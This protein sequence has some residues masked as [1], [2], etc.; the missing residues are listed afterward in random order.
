MKKLSIIL[1]LG[2]ILSLNL[3]SRDDG[4]QDIKARQSFKRLILSAHPLPESVKTI[5]SPIPLA[6]K[7]PL[8]FFLN[9]SMTVD[10]L[11]TYKMQNESSIAVNP[12][13]PNMLIGSAVDYRDES[14]TWVYFS[15]DAGKSWVNY[16]LGKAIPNW[17]S[18]ND[19]SVAYDGDGYAYLV[20]GGFGDINSKDWGVNFGENGVFISIS[21]DGGKTWDSSNTHI[22][23]ILHKGPQTID[24]TF[25]D[26]Y[27]IS[28]DNSVSSPYHNNLYIPWKRVTPKDSA[29]QIVFSKSTDKGKTWSTPLAVSPRKSGSSE[30]TTYGQSFPLV[31]TGPLG[32]IYLVWNDGIVH[33]VGFAKSTDGGDSFSEPSI[34]QHY[35]I[36]GITNDI[37]TNSQTGPVWRHTLKKVVRSEA[38]PVIVCDTTNSQF[39]G[40][41]YLTWAA[42]RIPNIYFSK[43]TDGGESW[44][45]P[46]IVHSDT[47]NDQF[48][49]WMAVDPKTGDIAVMYL[50]SR[51]DPDNIMVECYVSYSSDGGDTWTDRKVSD[52]NSDLRKNPFGSHFA[53]DYS[54]M[55]FYDGMIYPS[56]VD[57]RNAEKNIYDSDVYT[58]LIDVNS[59]MPVNNFKANTIAEYPDKIQLIWQAP[60]ERSFGQALNLNDYH[61]LLVRENNYFDIASYKT[62]F[63]DSNLNSYEKYHYKIYVVAGNDTSYFREDSAYAGGSKLPA[64]AG[65]I[66]AKGN[67]SNQ[68]ILYVK[69]P[70]KRADGITPLINLDNLALYDKDDNLLDTFHLSV[71]DTNKIISMEYNAD[72]SGYYQV[73]VKVRDSNFPANESDK[74]NSI[75]VFTGHISNGFFDNFD[76]GLMRYNVEGSWNLTNS[77]YYSADYSLTD[78][79]DGN[80]KK[81][82]ENYVYLYPVIFTKDYISLYFMHAAIVQKRDTAKVE[83]STN[84]GKTWLKLAGFNKTDYSYWN[85][86]V[87]NSKDWISEYLTEHK[88]NKGDTIIFKFSIVSKIGASSDGWYIDDIYINNETLGVN[89]IQAIKTRLYPNPASNF[90]F[91]DLPQDINPDKI[92]LQCYNIYGVKAN[93]KYFIENNRIILNISKLI[94]GVYFANLKFDNEIIPLKFCKMK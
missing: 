35:N 15:E 72:E 69:L 50:D 47:T 10:E 18:S 26:K 64:T 22:P 21:T 76:M 17:R 3:F 83:Y 70:N 13:S 28:V 78:S 8:P 12:S 2:C 61:Y 39:R 67:D 75:D 16:N 37:S 84:F 20:Y 63:L 29:T 82:T 14:S 57:M 92:D 90:V 45:N 48:W 85:D 24:S 88:F 44:S 4:N 41:V 59:P 43:S 91:I 79:P 5:K 60:T 6:T 40:N 31:A 11:G 54:G 36:F 49:Q 66:S 34:I 94:N 46:V 42:D 33:G 52:F 87:L 68:I 9:V 81:M 7:D 25:E 55:A 30:D 32:E 73:Y 1:F 53:G 93:P 71:N 74:S 58:S 65:I 80:Y 62:N 86:G 38:Y 23:V 89:D 77:F 51:D 19:P 56:W 27:Y